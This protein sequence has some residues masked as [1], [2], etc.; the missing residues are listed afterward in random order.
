MGGRKAERAFAAADVEV[1]ATTLSLDFNQR[2]FEGLGHYL[3][4]QR[5]LEQARLAE[6]AVGR[7]AEFERIVGI[8]LEGGM[9]DRSEQQVIAQKAAEM[10]A[11]MNDDR[12]QAQQAM[13]ELNAMSARPLDGLS[14]LQPLPADP[15]APEPFRS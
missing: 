6:A 7:M 1:A 12:F 4:A 13:A 11:K 2:V 14:G 3:R 15:G 5:A 8:R 10:R 9:S